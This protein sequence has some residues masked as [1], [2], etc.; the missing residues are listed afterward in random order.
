VQEFW[1]TYG[2]LGGAVVGLGIAVIAL[3]RRV[4]ELTDARLADMKTLLAQYSK[5]SSESTKTIESLGRSLIERGGRR[6]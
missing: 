4:Q 5:D 6:P 2:P 3:Y 1:L